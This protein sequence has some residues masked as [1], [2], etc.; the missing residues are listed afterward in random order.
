MTQSFARAEPNECLQTIIR[1]MRRARRR[2]TLTHLDDARV[3]ILQSEFHHI[4][5]ALVHTQLTSSTH[6]A[7]CDFCLGKTRASVRWNVAAVY[8][9]QRFHP[10]D[11]YGGVECFLREPP[12]VSAQNHRGEIRR[13]SGQQYQI[14]RI[15]QFVP[16]EI[17]VT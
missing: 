9:T 3:R 5:A 2:E 11:E 7:Q 1:E 17:H 10:F 6:R 13:A 14:A 16:T 15:P 4:L 12:R 8:L